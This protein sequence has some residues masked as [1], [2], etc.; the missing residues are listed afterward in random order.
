MAFHSI[1]EDVG[2]AVWANSPEVLELEKTINKGEGRKTLLFSLLKTLGLDYLSDSIDLKSNTSNI[3]SVLE[4]MKHFFERA[5]VFDDAGETTLDDLLDDSSSFLRG[6]ARSLKFNN[7][8]QRAAMVINGDG[9]PMYRLVPKSYF[10]NV[11]DSLLSAQAAYGYSKH[12]NKTLPAHLSSRFYRLNPFLVKYNDTYLQRIYEHFEH[13]TTKNDF[14]GRTKAALDETPKEWLQRNFTFGFLDSLSN[15]R[16]GTYN[17]FL[18]QVADKPR[19]PGLRIKILNEQQLL[20][21]IEAIIEQFKIRPE[22]FKNLQKNYTEE[23]FINFTV[24]KEALGSTSIAQANS[25]EVAKRVLEILQIKAKENLLPLLRD[26]Q[27]PVHKNLKSMVN[28][29]LTNDPDFKGHKGLGKVVK[30][31]PAEI[32]VRKSLDSGDRVYDDAWIEE[33]LP[34]LE[35]FYANHYVNSFALNQLFTGPMDLYK[36]EDDVLKRM[37]GVVAPGLR[38][39]V[40]SQ[41]GTRQKSKIGVIKDTEV[42]GDAIESL[43]KQMVPNISKERLDEM[44]KFFRAFETTD[45]QGFMLPSRWANL[46]NGFGRAYGLAKVLKPV[47][48]ATHVKEVDHGF[49]QTRKE[50]QEFIDGQAIKG[51]MIAYPSIKASQEEIDKTVENYRK[52]SKNPKLFN[53]FVDR[54]G[55]S[56]QLYEEARKAKQSEDFEGAID[57]LNALQRMVRAL[58]NSSASEENPFRVYEEAP[59]QMYLKYSSVVLSNE[60]VAK[61]P[62]LKKVRDFMETNQFEELLYKSAVKVGGA[63]TNLITSDDINAGAKLAEEHPG[64]DF[65]DN[66]FYKL[67]FNPKS[68][69][70]NKVSLFTQ[71]MYFLNILGTNSQEALAAYRAVSYL[72]EQKLVKSLIKQH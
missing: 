25:K 24:L 51:L 20:N 68:K 26:N 58:Q 33:A 19:I 40:H 7:E 5:R 27:I 60:L 6:V 56:S 13:D 42:K 23:R 31:L 52:R 44:M 17:H 62:E 36:N 55:I 70:D 14:T 28:R 9:S 49:F 66:N 22:F 50:A 38:P 39:L 59:Y 67:Q 72:L 10:Y 71:L 61:F 57:T 18:Y 37:A 16:L 30:A 41:L 15:G 2:L 47:Y 21:S 45:A 3:N 53:N 34:L 29:L 1:N 69:I 63:A 48:N 65:I 43:I 35:L 12:L 8:L 4:D 46:M 64:I 32:S 54:Y 11:A